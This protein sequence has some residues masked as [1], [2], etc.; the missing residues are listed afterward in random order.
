MDNTKGSSSLPKHAASEKDSTI[1]TPTY[2]AF[3]STN[4]TTY[5]IF[6]HSFICSILLFL[7]ATR[8][9][10]LVQSIVQPF[11][12]TLSLLLLR[13][14]FILT[15]VISFLHQ[16]GALRRYVLKFAEDE[17]KKNM[18]GTLVTVSDAQV[19]LWRGKVVAQVSSK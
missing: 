5:P 6:S 18:N 1:P 4:P 2:F 12:S 10:P 14:T 7:S 15:A 13:I 3:W 11:L 16:T 8:T 19:D 17:L 9:L